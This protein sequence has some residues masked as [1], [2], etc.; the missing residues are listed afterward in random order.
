M[1]D[2][3]V[4]DLAPTL[5]SCFFLPRP[6]APHFLAGSLNLGLDSCILDLPDA[7]ASCNFRPW[8]LVG[9]FMASRSQ[10]KCYLL[11]KA[12][13]D[14]HPKISTAP[15]PYSL[16]Q[17]PPSFLP[18]SPGLIRDFLLSGYPHQLDVIP[19]V[20]GGE[21]IARD[22]HLKVLTKYV[23]GGGISSMS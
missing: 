3:V 4:C 18:H 22:C 17:H 11:R 6:P 12:F 2:D 19:H 21:R 1:T 14:P 7:Q 16:S 13:F 15:V 9:C 5:L 23:L 20:V 8:L 10:F